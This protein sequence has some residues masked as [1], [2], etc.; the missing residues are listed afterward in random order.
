MYCCDTYNFYF[1]LRLGRKLPSRNLDKDVK[2]KWFTVRNV[3]RG[4]LKNMQ[5]E[6]NQKKLGDIKIW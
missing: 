5:N 6:I 1:F 3:F 4:K 2:H